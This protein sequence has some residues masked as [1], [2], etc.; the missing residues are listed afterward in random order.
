MERITGF[1]PIVG[2]SPKILILGTMPS[3]KSLECQEYYGF[4]RNQFWKIMG[5]LFGFDRN[6]DYELRKARMAEKGIAIW[7]VISSCERNG[8]LDQNIKNPEYNDIVGF[9]KT[10]PTIKK[11]I[12]NGGTARDIYKRR[13]LIFLPEIEMVP[14]Y[15]TS[16]A[17]AISYQRKLEQWQRIKDWL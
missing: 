2:E 10:R 9:I 11:V 13:F 6:A 14:F 3:V 12:L 7:D 17:S 4:G 15:S 8:S 5:E 16:P 1:E